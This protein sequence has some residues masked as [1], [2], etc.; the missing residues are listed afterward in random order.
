MQG[1]PANITMDGGAW[2]VSSGCC[3]WRAY[4]IGP[5]CL[6][7]MDKHMEILAKKHIETKFVKVRRRTREFMLSHN[8]L[9]K[10]AHVISQ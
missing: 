5:P 6:Q 3:I 8:N 7:V 9:T 1:G 2:L 10:G 4:P